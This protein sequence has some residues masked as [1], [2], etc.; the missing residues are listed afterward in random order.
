MN[1]RNFNEIMFHRHQDF[2]RV[3]LE[4]LTLSER[5]KQLIRPIG[6]E[7]FRG[8][9]GG[10][11]EKVD[12]NASGMSSK[13]VQEVIEGASQSTSRKA[14]EYRIGSCS[15]NG[16][17]EERAWA[18][19]V[20]EWVDKRQREEETEKDKLNELQEKKQFREKEPSME[21]DEAG[22]KD[23]QV[24]SELAGAEIV[25]NGEEKETNG[26]KERQGKVKMEKV[27]KGTRVE[28]TKGE[29]EVEGGR[30]RDGEEKEETLYTA[31][32]TDVTD[33]LLKREMGHESFKTS[34]QIK[35]RC[36]ETC[37]VSFIT[38]I[39]YGY[40]D[41]RSGYG[42]NGSNTPRKSRVANI[43]TAAAATNF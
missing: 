18:G 43:D 19:I 2:S 5:A 13:W 20:S 16:N 7:C 40:L 28:L 26:R 3:H 31:E 15:K 24:K 39:I 42:Y 11:E 9:I 14:G 6:F 32:E 22:N 8:T 17:R 34:R 30:D 35:C 41:A 37:G 25:L 12:H 1:N 29:G 27:G 23:A 38:P 10:K 36:S 21:R 33:R 4:Y